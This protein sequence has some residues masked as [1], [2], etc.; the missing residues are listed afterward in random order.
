LLGVVGIGLTCRGRCLRPLDAHYPDR[1][2]D[3][4]TQN[5]EPTAPRDE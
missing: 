1:P 4:A 2:R 5:E 3:H